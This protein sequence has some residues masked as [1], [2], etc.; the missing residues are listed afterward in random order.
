MVEP[1][2]HDDIPHSHAL[3]HQAACVF[4]ALAVPV[5]AIAQDIPI[6]LLL[7][8]S[9]SSRRRRRNSRASIARGHVDRLPH[10]ARGGRQPLRAFQA[11]RLASTRCT[12][13]STRTEES[14]A[15][16]RRL[17][18]VLS[19]RGHRD[20]AGRAPVDVPKLIRVTAPWDND[21][22]LEACSR[23]HGRR[24]RR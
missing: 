2:R 13:R 24:S 15:I 6:Q 21:R 22:D 20:Y 14:F 7:M 3:R 10:S 5:A 19:V 12:S 18:R 4:A 1:P 9:H 23:A 11:W 17:R 16:S 8:G